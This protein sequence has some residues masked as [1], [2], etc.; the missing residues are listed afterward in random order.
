MYQGIFG[1]FSAPFHPHLPS[2][3]KN[4]LPYISENIEKKKFQR[5]VQPLEK[6]YKKGY[7][8][9]FRKFIILAIML[10][11]SNFNL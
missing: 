9:F 6:I 7:I 1:A 11:N 4:V 5:K 8:H 2:K 3:L 10:E